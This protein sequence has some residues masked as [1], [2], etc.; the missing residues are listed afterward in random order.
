MHARSIAVPVLLFAAGLSLVGCRTSESRSDAAL[1][2]V[3]A[4]RPDRITMAEF[5]KLKKSLLFTDADVKA[6]RRSRAILE[7]R[8]D[9]L[10][11]VWYGFVGSN[12]HLVYYFTNK[13]DGKPNA[14]YLEKVRVRF[15]Q[16]VLDTADA[17]FDQTWLD[18]QYELGLRH[19]RAKKNQTDGVSSV[20]HIPMRHVIALSYPISTTIRPFLAGPGVTTEDVDAMHEA[21]RKA[22]LMTSILWSQPYANPGDF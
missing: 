21:W 17:N 3:E 5:E 14:E 19:H 8:A 9:E 4:T 12:E 18:K 7:P 1:S 16:W 22:V 10:L 11:G 13:S 6:L 2:V 20:D 15:R